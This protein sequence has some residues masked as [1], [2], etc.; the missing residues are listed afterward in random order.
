M[1]QT[2]LTTATYEYLS[3]SL[4]LFFQRRISKNKEIIREGL[5]A[6]DVIDNALRE[7]QATSTE[8]PADMVGFFV[9]FKE[10][11]ASQPEELKVKVAQAM[12]LVSGIAEGDKVEAARLDLRVL[13]TNQKAREAEATAKL[14]EERKARDL[15]NEALLG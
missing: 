7:F 13:I 8:A 11:L 6:S 3:L 2:H 10:C 9:K 4:S 12:R 5:G 14:D 15:E 1:Q